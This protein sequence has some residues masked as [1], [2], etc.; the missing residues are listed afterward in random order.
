MIVAVPS[1]GIGRCSVTAC[2]P[3]TSSAGLNVPMLP[4]AEPL[5][6]PITTGKVGNT[7]WSTPLVFSVVKANSTWPAPM[8]TAYRSA[9]F[10]VQLT[11]TGSL[12]E[13]TASGLSG[14][15]CSLSFGCGVRCGFGRDQ[16]VSVVCGQPPGSPFMPEF[17]RAAARRSATTGPILVG[18]S[19][20]V[21]DGPRTQ[22]S[23]TANT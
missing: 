1:T 8:P 2:W 7:C 17:G 15:W 14:I 20:G 22:P 19:S 12:V 16:E 13:P 4:I 18:S 6:Q 21:V 23:A 9:S 10:E 11:S 5:P 3:C